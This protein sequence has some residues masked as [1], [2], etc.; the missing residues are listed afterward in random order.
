MSSINPK[1]IN[2]N[3]S[4]QLLPRIGDVVPCVH[5]SIELGQPWIQQALAVV[6]NGPKT[7][8]LHVNDNIFVLGPVSSELGHV[9]KPLSVASIG[10]CIEWDNGTIVQR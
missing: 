8:P 4:L 3:A 9:C 10:P 5:A 1:Q 7:S 2:N 6:I